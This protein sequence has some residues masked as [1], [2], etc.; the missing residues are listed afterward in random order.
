ML[1]YDRIDTLEGIEANKWTRS[2]DCHYVSL[3]GFETCKKGVD[4]RFVIWN[5]S[6]SDAINRLNNSKLDVKGSI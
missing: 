2:N 5:M 1:H 3:M 6:K 4:Y